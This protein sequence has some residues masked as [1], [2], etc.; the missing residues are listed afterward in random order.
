MGVRR[1]FNSIN[2]G[3]VDKDTL[4]YLDFSDPNNR[5]LEKVSG[6][7]LEIDG[8]ASVLGYQKSDGITYV[9]NKSTN[10]IILKMK[11]QTGLIDILKTYSMTIDFFYSR[12]SPTPI[13]NDLDSTSIRI[14]TINADI[15]GCYAQLAI[16]M[17][18]GGQVRIYTWNGST[19]FAPKDTGINAN[20]DGYH[21]YKLLLNS[22]LNTVMQ[23]DG[24]KRWEGHPEMKTAPGNYVFIT[25]H[26]R[27]S[28]GKIRIRKGL[29][30]DD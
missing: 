21:K 20:V 6:K 7:T 18:Y 15:N 30:Y 24:I 25:M 16:T 26:T 3:G 11:D 27:G 28:F 10:P 17:Q 12:W 5:L 23:V 4:F 2:W 8:N 13:N 19:W 14:G 9:C 22:T 29:H 1:F